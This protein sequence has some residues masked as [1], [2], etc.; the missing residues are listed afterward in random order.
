[1]ILVIRLKPNGPFRL[2]M[3]RDEV[4]QVF[5]DLDDWRLDDGIE[6]N[7]SYIEM[8]FMREHFE[9]D[10]KGRVKFIQ[11]INAHY[12]GHVSIPCLFQGLGV[13]RIKA[14]ELIHTL[15]KKASND[16]RGK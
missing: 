10:T 11:L 14:E 16:W 9:Y 15:R 13:F 2:G 12:S 1:M 7:P 3:S 6:A 8:L 5:L 4:E